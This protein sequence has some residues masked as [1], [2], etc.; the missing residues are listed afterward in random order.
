MA[1][2]LTL[3][4]LLPLFGFIVLFIS[5]D[6]VSRFLTGLIACSTVFL[7]FLCF[8]SLFFLNLDLAG[9]NNVVLYNWIPIKGI[10]APLSLHIDALSLLMALIITGVGFL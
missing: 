4:L 6:K 9:A 3:A 10:D 1:V 2:I 5:A 8:C 7:S